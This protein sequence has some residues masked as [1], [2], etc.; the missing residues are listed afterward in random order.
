MNTDL[1]QTTRCLHTPFR[2]AKWRGFTLVELMMVAGIFIAMLGVLG[3]SLMMSRLSYL[4]MDTELYVQQEGRK[5]LDNMTA[6]LRVGGN[7]NNNVSIGSPGAQRLDFQLDRGYNLAAP[8]PVD[9]VCWGSDDPAFPT[10][11][12]HYVLDTVTTAPKAR[13]RRCTTANQLD[14][15]PVNFAGCR[16]VAN[17]V[18]PAL[19]MTTF[20]YDHPTRTITATLQV[21]VTSRQVA[22]GTLNT[23]A[24][25]LRIQIRLRNS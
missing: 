7:V 12:V 24:L 25:P 22:G 17:N 14:P 9:A 2:L 20:L 4:T 10:G 1:P 8:C 11:W 16:V 5:A 21:L 19:A 13:L 23:G 3:I 18:N 15:M 6:E